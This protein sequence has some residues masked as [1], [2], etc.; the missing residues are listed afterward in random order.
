M[1]AA[2]PYDGGLMRTLLQSAGTWYFDSNGKPYIANNPVLKAV[3]KNCK[4]IRDSVL[5]KEVSGWNEW[6][7][8]FNNGDSASVVTGV[9]IVG[10]IKA[11]ESE[12]KNGDLHQFQE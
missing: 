6:V 7:G 10:S 8:S 5:P 4:E 3:L 11:K 1:I 2:D 9:W 12:W